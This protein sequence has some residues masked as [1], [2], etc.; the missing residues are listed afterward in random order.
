MT[1]QVSAGYSTTLGTDIAKPMSVARAAAP[2]AALKNYTCS[3][4]STPQTLSAEHVRKVA[5]LSRLALTDAQVE[6]YQ[7]Q[8]SAVLTYINRLRE[9]DLANVE[10]MAHVG[11][12]HNRLD[13]DVP[14]DPLPNSVLMSMAPQTMPPFVKVPKVIDDGGGA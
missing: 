4:S 10:P 14:R 13:A 11:D 6:Q 12:M 2:R 3:M 9:L 7:H 5:M 1:E 8:L